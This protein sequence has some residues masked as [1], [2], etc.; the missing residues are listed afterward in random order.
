MAK[1]KISDADLCRAA[2]RLRTGVP[3]IKTFLAVETKNKGFDAQDRP[4]I[5]F[6][7]HWFH[8][9]TRGR[10]DA[11]HPNISNRSAGGY[12]SS[13]SQYDR[14]SIAFQL[15]P[16]AAMKSASWGLGQ[17]MGFNHLIVGYATV[18]EFVDAMKESEGKQL[19]A[20]VEFILHNHLD[21]ELRKH[22]WAG[23]A[24][25]YN[26]A[27]Y[28][29]NQYD[30]KLAKF[31][32]QFST[33]KQVDCSQVSAVSQSSAN[34]PTSTL[35]SAIE[36]GDTSHDT[37]DINNQVGED[38]PVGAPVEKADEGSAGKPEPPPTVEV[39][40]ARPSTFTRIGVAITGFLSMLATYGINAG[41]VIQGKLEQITLNQVLITA[42]FIALGAVAI[43]WY[44]RSSKRA[45]ARTMKYV[46][47]AE[48]K[49]SPNLKV[50]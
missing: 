45:Q 15:D 47:N 33:G 42:L 26:G 43:L 18:G 41:S 16:E 35:T 7:R 1:P 38:V 40:A 10:Y 9:L 4:L 39:T 30:T 32:R 48:D 21:D 29:K 37:A 46:E 8:K 28:K 12:G 3:E 44:D 34:L 24:R 31:Y 50:I 20:S 36:T 19:D 5:L 13:A 2:K 14:F 11:T 17:V 49:T 23:F 22:D 27:A 6:E 25:G